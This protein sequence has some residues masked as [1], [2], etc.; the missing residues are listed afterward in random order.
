M[1]QGGDDFC[2]GGF[3]GGA[4]AV[5]N[6]A[7][8][9]SESAATG[10][11]FRVE[12]VE[13]DR[14]LLGRE[15]GEIHAGKFAGA[16]G[17]LQE[18]L[19]GVFE[20]FDF[21]VADGKAE[22]RAHFCFVK[23]GIA[24]AFVFLHDA[25]FGVEYEGSGKRGD[26]AIVKTD[27]IG[28]KSDGIVDAEFVREFL[29]GVEIIVVHDESENLQ[30]VFIF[31]LERDEIGNFGAARSTPRGPKIYENDFAVRA[32]EGDRFSIESR[33]FEIRRGIRIAYKADR[34]LLVLGA[35]RGNGKAKK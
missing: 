29:D 4:V 25:S 28:G 21:D 11:G 3:A 22:E 34:G 8:R 7:L 32:G 13:C 18:N 35:R 15:F 23:N 24:E 19:T 14:F 26:A 6:A 12:F 10:A 2:G 16:V 33:Q 9:E 30:M 1:R 20:R 17:I 31:F 27:F 5:V